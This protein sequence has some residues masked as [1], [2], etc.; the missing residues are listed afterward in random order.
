MI[1][2]SNIYYI[3]DH[4]DKRTWTY[5]FGAC[6]ATTV[7]IPSFHNYRIWSFLGL[8]MTTYTAWYLTIAALVH[9]QVYTTLLSIYMHIIY[10]HNRIETTEDTEPLLNFVLFLTLIP[11]FTFCCF[12]CQFIEGYKTL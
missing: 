1:S 11:C 5:I 3:N 9:G 2:C 12:V 4:L 10:F 8:F 7:F 6:C